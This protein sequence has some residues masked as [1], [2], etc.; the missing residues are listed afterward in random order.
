MRIYQ[1]PNLLK[2]IK[3]VDGPESSNVDHV[4]TN[5]VENFDSR[6]NNIDLNP[7]INVDLK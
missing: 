3:S 6:A 1:T 7:I 5:L 4:L 2:F